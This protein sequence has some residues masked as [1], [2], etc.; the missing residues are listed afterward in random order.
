MA[1]TCAVAIGWR[2]PFADTTSLSERLAMATITANTRV[3]QPLPQVRHIGFSDLRDSLRA[4]LDDFRAIP[5]QAIF[6]CL[7]YPLVGLF[8]WSVMVRYDVLPLLFPLVAGF[9]LVGPFAAVGLY[10]LSRRREEGLDSEWLHAFDVF[11]SPAKWS[12]FA[13]GI[14]LL[15]ILGAWLGAAR[16]IYLDTMGDTPIVSVNA[17]IDR[18]LSTHAGHMLILIG[19]GV[20]FLFALLT[21]VVGVVSFPLVLDRK[22]DAPTALITSVRAVLASPVQIVAWGFIVAALLVLGSIPFLFGLAVV[23]PVLGH[24]TW[25]LYRKV[26]V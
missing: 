4:G 1:W 9:A 21:L 5:S 3:T 11:R 20:G 14:L 2:A 13:L 24:A 6:L 25:H 19:N 8:L 10:E 17:F 23:M 12:I 18:V 16:A 22:V 7:I 15:A 26:V